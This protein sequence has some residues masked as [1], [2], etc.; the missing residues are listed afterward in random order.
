[1]IDEIVAAGFTTIVVCNDGSKD[2]T[3]QIIDTK[4]CEHTHAHIC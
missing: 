2:A 4:A 3:E 1:V